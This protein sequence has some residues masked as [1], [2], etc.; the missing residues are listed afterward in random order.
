MLPTIE[1][2]LLNK[3]RRG[4]PKKKKKKERK[5]GF[6]IFVVTRPYVILHCTYLRCDVNHHAAHGTILIN[7]GSE[8]R[9]C[10]F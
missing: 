8:K 9:F 7:F 6:F 5:K 10:I 1:R 4:P 2:M 3:F